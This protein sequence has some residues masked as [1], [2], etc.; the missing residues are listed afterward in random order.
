[1]KYK[2]EISSTAQGDQEYLQIISE[3]AFSVN[4]VLLG[5]FDLLDSREK[6]DPEPEVVL[7]KATVLL[8]EFLVK[9]DHGFELGQSFVKVGE[10]AVY[11]ITQIDE[12]GGKVRVYG[13]RQI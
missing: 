3:D 5:Q 10:D 7:P 6:A 11:E 12:K 1:M 13:V 2:I 8:D 4:V 9:G